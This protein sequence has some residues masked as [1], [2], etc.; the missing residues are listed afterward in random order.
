MKT[1]ITYATNHGCTE[2][3]AFLLNDFLGGTAQLINLKE[4]SN[5][6]LTNFDRIII[7]G[8]IHA[9]RIQK[10][11]KKFCEKHKNELK[12]KELGLFICCMEEGEKAQVQFNDAFPEILRQN[13]KASACLGG[14]FDFEKM[15]AFQKMIIKKVTKLNTTPQLLTTKQF[16]NSRRKWIKFLIRFCFLFSSDKPTTCKT[17]VVRI[18]CKMLLTALYIAQH[19]FHLHCKL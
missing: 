17:F 19:S 13:A 15:T 9:G 12:N 6:D 5:P 4:N 8:S 16:G 2:K 14:E 10:N 18:T 3:T 7:G 1:L 11:I